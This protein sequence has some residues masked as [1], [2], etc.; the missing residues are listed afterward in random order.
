MGDELLRRER[1]RGEKFQRDLAIEVVLA[2][3]IYRPHAFLADQLKQLIGAKAAL[4]RVVQ[5]NAVMAGRR[6]S[7]RVRGLVVASQ[8]NGGRA[9]GH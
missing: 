1:P 8:G 4:R 7:G 6:P 9:W 3:P 5:V 2:R